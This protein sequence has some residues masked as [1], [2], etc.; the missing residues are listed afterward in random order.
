MMAGYAQEQRRKASTVFGENKP[1]DL[2][3]DAVKVDDPKVQMPTT[4]PVV[5]QTAPAAQ[6]NTQQ[7]A[8]EVQQPKVL[9]YVDQLRMLNPFVPKTAE[10]IE[11]ERRKEKRD[12]MFASIGDGISA[13]ANLYFTTQGAPNAYNQRNSMSAQT[14]ARW[15]KYNKEYQDEMRQYVPLYMQAMQRDEARADGDRRWR[16]MLEQQDK[17]DAR[18][19]EQQQTAREAREQQQENWERTFEAQQQQ[20]EQQQANADRTFEESKRQFNVTNAR[21][22]DRAAS[23]N[24]SGRSSSTPKQYSMH[25]GGGTFAVIPQERMNIHNVTSVF[26]RLPKEVRN[27]AMYEPMYDNNKRPVM[28]YEL[29]ANGNKIKLSGGG[30]KKKPVMKKKELSMDD[31]LKVIG[32]NINTSQSARAA[33]QELGGSFVNSD[34]QQHGATDWSQYITGEVAGGSNEG[35]TDW[36]QYITG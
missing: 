25:L 28:E 27:S 6:N 16:N 1:A 36:S 34:D 5:N 12:K 19:E 29:D 23:Q 24:G 10:Q 11:A 17:Q 26:N 9:S 20:R 18:Y 32:E 14:Q 2:T 3:R 21:L 31:M 7:G 15:D 13:L 4:A 35:A 8:A 30:Y 22:A 33:W